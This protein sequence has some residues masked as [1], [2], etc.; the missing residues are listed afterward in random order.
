MHPS[1]VRCWFCNLSLWMNMFKS[2][3][4]DCVYLL[5][6][7]RLVS[8]DGSC[9][10]FQPW[11][12]QLLE[13]EG[14]HPHRSCCCTSVMVPEKS[15]GSETVDAKYPLSWK[16][17][18]VDAQVWLEWR[19]YPTIHGLEMSFWWCSVPRVWPWTHHFAIFCSC[20]TNFVVVIIFFT[21][22]WFKCLAP[23]EWCGNPLSSRSVSTVCKKMYK[24]FG[25]YGANPSHHSPKHPYLASFPINV[26]TINMT[27]R[28][29]HFFN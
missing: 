29:T 12:L 22:H 14:E 26:H 24:S 13:P 5:V 10:W 21:R 9:A 7:L 18:S 4:L 1:V 27:T 20:V 19:S 17:D 16:G 23:N 2:T 3:N 8:T 28:T 11:K 6:M 25:L 15:F